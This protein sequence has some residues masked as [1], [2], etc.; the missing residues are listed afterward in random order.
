MYFLSLAK[1]NKILAQRNKLLKTDYKNPSIR[2]M[3][4]VWDTQLS[5]YGANLILAR[6]AYVQKLCPFAEQ[7][8]SELSSKK[9]L[10]SM[11]Y[12]CCAESSTRAELVA[13]LF[14]KL[15]ENVDKDLSLF[16]TSYGP[17]RDDIKIS[18]NDLDSRKFASQGQQRS[19]ALSV[20][21]AEL[22]LFEKETGESP[23]LLLDD[24]LSELDEARKMKLL[25]LASCTQTLIT[26]TNFDFKLPF[27]PKQLII[28]NGNIIK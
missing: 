19:A 15:S 23:V 12:E 16:F 25:N 3:L 10:L 27:V 7:T 13:E 28:E 5:E 8:H 9:E 14:L 1:Y 17:H 18:I 24:V 21:I 26:C 2:D 11:Q 4:S 20:K 6:S 22:S